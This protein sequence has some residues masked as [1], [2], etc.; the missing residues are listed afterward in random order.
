MELLKA[1][2]RRRSWVSETVYV[3]LNVALA[4]GVLL[5]V[6]FFET[7][8][9]AFVLVLLSKWRLVA[10]RPRFWFANIQANLVD[11]M[12]GLSAV[13]LI[14]QAEGSYVIQVILAVLFAA[15]LL[16]LKP[17]SRRRAMSWQAGIALFVSVTALYSVGYQWPS[18]VTVLGMWVIGYAVARHVLST[19]D[20]EK[21][22][23]LLSLLW[24]FVLAELGWLAY[25]WTIAYAPFEAVTAIKVPQIAIIAIA[26]GYITSLMYDQYQHEGKIRFRRIR[27]HVIFTAGLVCMLLIF[28][29]GYDVTGL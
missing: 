10:V 20:E 22:M 17:R 29:N 19:Y 3:A 25:H 21:D 12:V 8:L 18:V 1:A 28:F 24:G 15:W 4:V 11:I 26:L 5:L 7:P 16:I 23:T 27:W 2:S 13:T 14:W 6:M 9:A